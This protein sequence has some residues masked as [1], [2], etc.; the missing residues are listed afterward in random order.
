MMVPYYLIDP[1]VPLAFA[2]NYHNL[3]WAKYVTTV[4]AIISL[5]TWLVL[6]NIN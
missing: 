2:F 6:Y 4:G 1:N 5:S 3:N